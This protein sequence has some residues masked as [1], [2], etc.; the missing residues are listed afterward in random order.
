MANKAE[1]WADNAPGKFYIDMN[2]DNCG[3]CI[4]EAPDNIREGEDHSY[5]FKQPANEAEL[6][7][8]RNAMDSCP[9]EAIGDDGE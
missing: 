7:A 5:V 2:C 6:Q 4:T 1:K 3:L 8:L 9:T